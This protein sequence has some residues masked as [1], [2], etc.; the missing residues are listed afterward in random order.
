MMIPMPLG[1]PHSSY[2]LRL[3]NGQRWRLSATFELSG[4]LHELASILE[5][6]S[7]APNGC[8]RLILRHRSSSREGCQN[9][10]E[11]LGPKVADG[12][13]RHSWREQDQ[14]AY[15]TWDH[16]DVPDVIL[17]LTLHQKRPKQIIGMWQALSPIYQEIQEAG[18]L[19][20]HAALL[21]RDA[22]GVLLLAPPGGGK[23]TCCRRLRPPWI[24]LCDDEALV[25][26]DSRGQYASHPFPTWS[27]LLNGQPNRSWDVQQHLPLSALFFLR[28][29]S[30]PGVAGLTPRKAAALLYQS[31]STQCR[32]IWSNL[33]LEELRRRRTRLFQNAC[34]LADVV[35]AFNLYASLDGCFWEDMERV[36]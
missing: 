26:R 31:A 1:E 28:H 27:E 21:G 3:A 17:E 10:L 19:P 16:P 36:L 5:L 12:L 13:P 20:L 29:A 22:I 6:G 23:S 8:P 32:F 25:V 35:P 9:P 30:C 15:K 18:G 11:G 4:W 2:C 14:L 33:N 34:E 24:A 7:G